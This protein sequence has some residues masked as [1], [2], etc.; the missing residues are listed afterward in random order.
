MTARILVVDDE[1]I[2]L[3]NLEHILTREGYEVT[4][5]QSGGQALS[6]LDDWPF[7][8]VLTDLKMDKVDGLEVLRR[9]KARYP[10]IEVI[11]ITAF[12]TLETAV[13]AMKEGAFHYVAKPFRLEE[14]RRSVAEALEKRRLKR[15]NQALR[16][17]LAA[18]QGRA[19]LVTRDGSMHKLLDM[20]RQIAPTGCN[21]L[22]TG[23][24]GTGKE[25]LARYVHEHGSRSEGSFLAINCGAFNDDLLANELFG[26]EKGAFTGSIGKQ[27][28]IAAADGGTLFLDEITEMPTAM[29]A[30]LLRVVQEHEVLPLGSIRPI[31]VDV[32]FIAASNRDVKAW[33]ADG[34]FRQD[35]WFRLNVVN[36]HL[37]PL[38]ERPEDIPLLAQ[39]FL[40]RSAPLMGKEIRDIS[41]EAMALL[42]AHFWPGNVREL[43]NVIERSAALCHGDRIEAAHL[44]DELRQLSVRAFR[45]KDGQVP[46]LEEHERDYILWVLDEA[47][48]NQTLAAQM[49]GIDR[50]SL[51]R[52]LK[53]YKN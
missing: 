30:K 13:Q 42:K 40:A 14:V 51:W 26:H 31:K 9:C 49:L 17:Q 52:K 36:L 41:E 32:R 11:L 7:D 43:E 21:V 39:H 24:S 33:V 1:R 23:E 27:G 18:I 38:S 20:A 44:P 53:R 16:E 50:V 37:P 25:V 5:T 28:L 35:L 2:A 6:L 29:Q 34:R 3:R 15:E 45:R 22:L 19:R 46:T 47:N 8:L 4:T 12:A 48:G 10:D